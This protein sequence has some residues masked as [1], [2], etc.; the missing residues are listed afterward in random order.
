MK[1]YLLLTV[2]CFTLLQACVV[3]ENQYTAVPPGIWRAT[4]RLDAVPNPIRE[5]PTADVRYEDIDQGE[6][7]FNFEVV[8]EDDTNF[9]IEIINGTERIKAE[10]ITYG[11]NRATGRDSIVINFPVFDS[12]ITAFYEE[13]V[14]E[15]KWIVNNK[16]K[17]SIPFVAFHGKDYRFTELKK[18]PVLDISGNWKVMFEIESEAPYPA[19]GEF[20]QD[21]NYLS[22]TFRTETG[23]YRFLEGTVQANKVYLSCFDG[24]H[25]FLF[26]AKILEDSTMI[27]AF[28]SGTHYKTLWEAERADGFELSNADSLTYLKAGYDAF[29]FEFE[30]TDGQVV[31]ISDYDN[32]VK[33]IQ[34]FGT[35]CPNCR[36]ETN[37]LVDY[38]AKHPE[39]DI[40]VIGLAFEKYREKE[41]AIAAIERFRK[42]MKVDYELL[43]A[44]YSDKSEASEALPMLNRVISYPTLIFIDQN[45]QVRRIH[46]GFSGPAT[47][48]Y[49]AYVEDFEAFMQELLS[50]TI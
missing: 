41:K 44:G 38:L 49:K 5:E 18:E 6:I 23:D 3:I 7:P 4:L 21:G 29:D 24:A 9:Y 35:W 50:E 40:A 28:R 20:K 10:D 36:D 1:Y 8:Y 48:K 11:H 31:R 33:L 16:E 30:N 37:F 27:G 12:Y 34:I 42:Q 17:Y 32:K 15:G 25:A 47:S 45:N 39:E 22:G 13:D 2:L 14:I 43:L 19:V 26:E 46:T